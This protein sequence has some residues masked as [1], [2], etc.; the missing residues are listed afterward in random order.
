MTGPFIAPAELTTLIG[1]ALRV[2][3]DELAIRLIPEATNRI[4]TCDADNLPGGLLAAPNSSTGQQRWDTLIATAYAWALRSRG[5]SPAAWMTDVPALHPAWLLDG[6]L[7]ASDA[8]R[9]YI[10]EQTPA[11]FLNKGILIRERDLRTA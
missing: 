6:D 11:E 3:D 9:T 8:W 5:I 4:L 7:A 1:E 10:R 2:G